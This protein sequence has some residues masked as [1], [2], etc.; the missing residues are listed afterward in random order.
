MWK[1]GYLKCRHIYKNWNLRKEVGI[2]VKYVKKQVV[3]LNIRNNYV[4]IMYQ[5]VTISS[6][7]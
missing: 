4:A 2:T 5:P 3:C 7:M 6:N 1:A